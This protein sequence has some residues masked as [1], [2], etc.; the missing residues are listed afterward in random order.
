M[1]VEAL[2]MLWPVAV[3]LRPVIL[4]LQ[5]FVDA[6]AERIRNEHR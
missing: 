3:V 2:L 6:Y 1:F 4:W 5:K